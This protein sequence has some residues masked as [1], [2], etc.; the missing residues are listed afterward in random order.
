MLY[1]TPIA[2]LIE[3][4]SKLPGIGVKTATRLAF[5]TIGMSDEDVN[6]F[7]KNLLAAKR[8]LTYCSICGN[9]TDDDPCS[10]CT[11]TSRD[12]TTILVVEDAKDVSAMEK[13]Q[14]YHGYYHVLHGLISPM[15]GV[16][17]DDINLKSLITR[18]MDGKVT[19][20]IVA[21]NATADGEAT[22]MYISRVLKPAGIKVTRL[23]RGLAVGSDI[24]Y[25]D[26]VTLL[27]AIENRTEL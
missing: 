7:A 27:R 24:E 12:Q 25:A 2:K 22:S 3:S 15:N 26:E 16:G 14:E 19:E 10:I 18:L 20:V 5:Y 9:L 17:P 11:D 8:E 21:T 23:A 6:D 1:P 4:Y 13:I